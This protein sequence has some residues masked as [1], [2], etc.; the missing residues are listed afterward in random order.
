[1]VDD[2]VHG[3]EPWKSD[4]TAEGTVLLRDVMPGPLGS[5][6]SK[7]TF[8]PASKAAFVPVGTQGAIAFAAAGGVQ[9]LELWMTDGTP[10]GTRLVADVAEGAMS[11]SPSL[12]TVSGPR[13]FFV[14][15]EGVHGRELWSVKQAAFQSR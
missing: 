9:G 13:L 7:A 2:G 8:M 5:G 6:V 10:E 1:V 15:D 4:G 3:G 12:L 11:A 14:A